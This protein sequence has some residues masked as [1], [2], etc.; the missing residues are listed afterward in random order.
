[1]DYLDPEGKA[2]R[3]IA[4]VLWSVKSSQAQRL[5]ED[6]GHKPVSL[7]YFNAAGVLDISERPSIITV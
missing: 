4:G 2:W 3:L 6:I 1:M 5:R 7:D